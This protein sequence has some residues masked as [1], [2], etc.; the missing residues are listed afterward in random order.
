MGIPLSTGKTIATLQDFR[1]FAYIEPSYARDFPIRFK[2]FF[3]KFLDFL[4]CT[5]RFTK[6]MDEYIVEFEIE[7]PRSFTLV[8]GFTTEI[9]THLEVWPSPYGSEFTAL[10]FKSASGRKIF[11]ILSTCLEIYQRLPFPQLNEY[12]MSKV[13]QSEYRLFAGTYQRTPFFE[14]VKIEPVDER[15]ILVSIEEGQ[16]LTKVHFASTGPV[17]I[18]NLLND[19][20]R[21]RVEQL[22]SDGMNHAKEGPPGVVADFLSSRTKKRRRS[23]RRKP[24]RLQLRI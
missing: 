19:E 1:Y 17:K 11:K 10:W 12:V 4:N 15:R 13:L 8:D 9:A 20:E 7:E 14:W 18:T 2:F 24:V 16:G 21:S 5:A 23:F 22:V 6:M 3:P